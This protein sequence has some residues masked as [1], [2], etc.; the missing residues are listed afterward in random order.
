VKRGGKN[1]DIMKIGEIIKTI[2][3]FAPLALQESWDNAGLIVGDSENIVESALLC[4]DVT[5]EVLDEAISK[6]AGLVI[7][8]HPV[9][10]RGLKKLTGSDTTERI[11][12]MAIRNN[13]SLYSAHTNIDKIWGGV[14]SRIAEKLGLK[15]QEILT[16]EGGILKK[17]IVFV[18]GEHASKVREAIFSSGAGHIGEY[19]Q[20]SFNIAGEGSFRGSDTTDPFA[21]KP[22]VLHFEKEIRIETIFPSFL[23]NRIIKSMIEAHPYEEVAYD[24]YSLGNKWDRAGIGMT[25]ELESPLG[26]GEFLD[27]LRTVFKSAVI[28]HTS[29][30]D[31]KIARVAVCGGS[32]SSLIHAA[33]KSGADAYVSGDFKYHDFFGAGSGFMIADIGHFES[34][35]FTMEIFND[36]LTKKFPNFA[37]HFSE[38]N[39]NPI[40]YFK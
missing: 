4:L 30:P 7:S 19:D 21:G 8:H 20:C 38:V 11:V 32:G 26:T 28:R 39:T 27:L 6:G 5:E 35:Q 18:P 17:L 16:T 1:P 15:K 24:I 3:D 2:E 10:F 13:I 25:G 33:R 23:E 12:L 34:E 31:K 36:L 29:P 14:N 40:H 37:V 9:I 22:G